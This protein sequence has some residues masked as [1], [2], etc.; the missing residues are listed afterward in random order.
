M[1]AQ[2]G[3]A[4]VTRDPARQERAAGLRRTLVVALVANLSVAGA[5][6][7]YGALSGSVVMRVDGLCSLLDAGAGVAGL[8]EVTLTGRPPARSRT[9]I[10]V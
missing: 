5:K 7:L 3:K 4:D 8:A 1:R 6:L 10:W 2:G 9:S